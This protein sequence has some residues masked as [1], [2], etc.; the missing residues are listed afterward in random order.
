M[1]KTD[2]IRQMPAEEKVLAEAIKGGYLH[3]EVKDEAIESALR[4]EVSFFPL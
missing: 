4:V 2:L 1:F 3:V